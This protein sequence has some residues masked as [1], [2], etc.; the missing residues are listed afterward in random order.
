MSVV[1]RMRASVASRASAGK[2]PRAVSRSRLLAIVADAAID[3]LSLEVAHDHRV[4]GGGERLRDA[5]AHGSGAENADLADLL[6]DVERHVRQ[7]VL[8][9][10]TSTLPRSSAGSL[11]TAS[12]SERASS[13]SP[14]Q[15]SLRISFAHSPG[16][17][18]AAGRAWVSRKCLMP[19]APSS[20]PALTPASGM[21]AVMRS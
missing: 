15:R 16:D 21:A 8:N 17:D 2:F 13:S 10:P 11:L 9:G 6:A 3:I 19:G 18:C 14:I 5:V 20:Q 7:S 4:A 1:G 12:C